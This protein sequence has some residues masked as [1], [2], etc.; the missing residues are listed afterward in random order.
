M[1]NTTFV[2]LGFVLAVACGGAVPVPDAVGQDAEPPQ[3]QI[4]D[5]FVWVTK[6]FV[7]ERD[8]M[9]APEDPNVLGFAWP[10]LESAQVRAAHL[11]RVPS[12]GPRRT[13]PT[14]VAIY[15]NFVTYAP[16]CEDGTEQIVV[17]LGLEQ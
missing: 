6:T 7:C 8:I 14:S 3:Q 16:T 15:A 4:R 17:T 11:M 1:R 12:L 2:L 13:Q 5:N 9:S 10:G